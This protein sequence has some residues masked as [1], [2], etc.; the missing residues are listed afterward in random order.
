MG[1]VEHQF[2]QQSP[3]WSASLTGPANESTE[4]AGTLKQLWKPNL[5]IYGLQVIKSLTSGFESDLDF[6]WESFVT[7]VWQFFPWHRLSFCETKYEM[8]KLAAVNEAVRIVAKVAL[9]LLVPPPCRNSRNTT[10]SMRW[11]ASGFQDQRRSPS[12]S[13]SPSRSPAWW[14]SATTHLTSTHAT[15]RWHSS[16]LSSSSEN[17]SVSY[18]FPLP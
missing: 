4:D 7:L 9:Q 12:T 13:R 15:S 10:F 3:V 14:T 5:E 6:I 17:V 16:F 8:R 2:F 18:N 1:I 11:L